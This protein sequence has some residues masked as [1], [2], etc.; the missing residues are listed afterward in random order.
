MESWPP[1][2]FGA[3]PGHWFGAAARGDLL[4]LAGASQEI[5][6]LDANTGDITA[7]FAARIAPASPHRLG[8]C[9]SIAIGESWVA[10]L[11]SDRDR[12]GFYSLTG[13]P[14]ADVQLSSLLAGTPLAPTSIGASGRYLGVA[15]ANRL[16]LLQVVDSC[17][18]AL[19]R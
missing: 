15:Y 11:D 14:A 6:L 12:I 17:S 7:R 5:V 10:T 2:P 1:A 3:P 9:S 8:D 18:E 19:A 13:E 16:V 4:A